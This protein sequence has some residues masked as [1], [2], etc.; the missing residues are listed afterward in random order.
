MLT[1]LEWL[2][3][4]SI[5]FQKAKD[6]DYTN[7]PYE[8]LVFSE[9]APDNYEVEGKTHGKMSHAIKHLKEFEPAFVNTI[10]SKVKKTIIS[11]LEEKPHWFCKVWNTHKGFK[12]DSGI[13]AVNNATS[14]AVL[15]TLDLINDK[16]QMG[17][18]L[19]KLDSSIK[20]FA[21]ELEQK[22]NDIMSSKLDKAVNLDKL[23]IKGQALSKKIKKSSII[24]FSCS[25]RGGGNFIVTIDF[26]D[27]SLI[28]GKENDV[29]TT[30]YRFR[31]AE[32]S[33]KSTVIKEFFNKRLDPKNPE[34]KAILKEM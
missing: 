7:D 14:N 27:Q 1:F 12:S 5:K 20:P 28:I 19:L 16:T 15:N 2:E 18:K 24:Q 3:E 11:K 6:Q 31:N 32:G 33:G 34:I 9:V 21:V 22:Y 4:S 10:V 30:M 8:V 25:G 29:V 17:E 23:T 26:T 13:D